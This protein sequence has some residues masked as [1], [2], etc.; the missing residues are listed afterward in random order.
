MEIQMIT[1]TTLKPSVPKRLP[2]PN[3][4]F[5]HFAETLSA[6]ELATLKQVR[7]FMETNVAPVINTYWVKELSVELSRPC[8]W[9]TP[10]VVEICIGLEI[11]GYLPAEF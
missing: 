11:N 4:D 5:Y 7:A 3:S 8:P 10:T 1:V 9:T 6:D 2:P